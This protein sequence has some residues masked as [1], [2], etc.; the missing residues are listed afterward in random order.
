MSET[1]PA[2]SLLSQMLLLSVLLTRTG[3]HLVLRVCLG[4]ITACANITGPRWACGCC[5]DLG[6]TWFE[7]LFAFSLKELSLELLPQASWQICAQHSESQCIG[8]NLCHSVLAGS[9]WQVCESPGCPIRG[10]GVIVALEPHGAPFSILDCAWPFA[11]VPHTSCHPSFPLLLHQHPARRGQSRL[12][13]LVLW[14]AVS[15]EASCFSFGSEI[16][17]LIP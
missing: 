5:P 6:Y 11:G 9:L 13:L 17:L 16:H 15:P 1:L 4:E 14:A 12:F 8:L 10:L 3:A 7:V 2:W